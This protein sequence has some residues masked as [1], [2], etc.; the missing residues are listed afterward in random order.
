MTVWV[1]LQGPEAHVIL[2]LQHLPQGQRRFAPLGVLSCSDICAGLLD[3]LGPSLDGH[4]SL[5]LEHHKVHA[6]YYLPR[7]CSLVRWLQQVT[8]IAVILA[9]R[10]SSSA[11]AGGTWIES[12][13]LHNHDKMQ[14]IGC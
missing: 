2:S 5:F 12:V 1:Q 7:E 14:C 10:P 9:S 4:Q 11:P 3:K 13:D 6:V 8:Y